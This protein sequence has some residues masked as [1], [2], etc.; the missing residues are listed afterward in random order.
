M[1]ED[2]ICQAGLR[3]RIVTRDPLKKRERKRGKERRE[4]EG[5]SQNV[6]DLNPSRQLHLENRFSYHG[7][8]SIRRACS[9]NARNDK[10]FCP[11]TGETEEGRVF[12]LKGR[13]VLLFFAS[14]ML[15]SQHFLL[16]SP[17]SLPV[18][19]ATLKVPRTTSK[20]I[21][22]QST[23]QVHIPDYLLLPCSASRHKG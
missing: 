9:I 17:A 22:R 5:T 23:R 16:L 8:R 20:R 6:R 1:D 18:L 12:A 10:T 11:C 21:V 4:R 13:K 15:L 19:L 14:A 7:M 3:P 2:F